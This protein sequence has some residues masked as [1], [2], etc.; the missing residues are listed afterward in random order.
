MRVQIIQKAHKTTGFKRN[1]LQ[2]TF[3]NHS[4]WNHNNY[5][6]YIIEYCAVSSSDNA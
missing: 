1:Y 6:S 4:K 3:L 5:N 2:I